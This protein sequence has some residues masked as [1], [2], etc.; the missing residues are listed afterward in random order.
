MDGLVFQ[1]FS[2]D[3]FDIIAKYL[4]Q[5]DI[6]SLSRTC[7]SINTIANT[8]L[9]R[10][11]TLNSNYSQFEKEYTKEQTTY[12]RTRAN[13]TLLLKSL[14]RNSYND[15]NLRKLVKVLKIED[16]PLDFY[17]FE[18]CLL[19]KTAD[20][21]S[22]FKR[23]CLT[24]LYLT[25]PISFSVL[26]YLLS[27]EYSRRN[28]SLLCFTVNKYANVKSVLSLV[29]DPKLKFE[30]LSTLSIGP[31]KPDLGVNLPLV[32]IP[33]DKKQMLE[34]L[35][36]I[37]YHHALRLADL[38]SFSENNLILE[39][40]IFRTLSFY[41]NLKELCLQ[42]I[43]LNL[44]IHTSDLNERENFEIFSNLTY[45]EL[46]DVSLVG[47]DMNQSILHKLYQYSKVCRLRRV[48]LDIRSISND[49]IPDFFL[50]QV[51]ENQI[52]EFDVTIRH[53]CMHTIPLNEL[54]EKYIHY[55]IFRQKGSL[56][57]L[58]VEIKCE[59]NL[60][61]LGGQLQR[62]HIAQILSNEFLNL[63]SLRLEADFD[64]I[65]ELKD[66]LFL[67]MPNLENLWVVGSN[68]VPVHFGLGNMHPGIYDSWW[69]II[70]L[71]KSLVKNV[72]K[73]PLRYIKIH[74]YLFIVLDE[75][76]RE[77][78]QPKDTI[79]KIFEGLTR[80]SFLQGST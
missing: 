4:I 67:N 1:L 72:S 45:L 53:N 56:R 71:P 41:K 63:R 23:G 3:L 12:I 70:D 40:S 7:K 78:V 10:S 74:K 80:V 31:L 21:L 16:L 17:D 19:G 39:N 62:V 79:D 11:I 59:R 46:T 58:S 76:E 33:D 36:L 61:S 29:E 9:Y 49:L 52:L 47:S 5:F 13:F 77:R 30:N 54:I 25:S 6:I 60:V 18:S 55:I 68:A 22:F 2:P 57:K 35:K 8:Y 20:S 27:D 48:K 65:L 43:N 32:L 38:A 66:K 34:S 24:K 28:L 69:R 42:S 64:S 44:E 51:K 73:H 15:S 75:G 26:K 14:N 50:F 37:Y